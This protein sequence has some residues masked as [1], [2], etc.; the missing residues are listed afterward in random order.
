MP[1]VD[2]AVI[3]DDGDYLK[4]VGDVLVGDPATG[5]AGPAGPASTVPG[6]AGP[7]GAAGATGAAGTPGTPGDWSTAQTVE[8]VA[9]ATYTVVAADA[10]KLKRLAVTATVTLPSAGP[11]AGQRV[12]FACAGVGTFVLGSGATWD[13]APTPSAVA[14]AVGSYVTAVKMGAATWSLT[15][16]LA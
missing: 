11:T 15:G 2:L 1:D 9:G 12:D 10:G 3:L 5:P 13:I 16:D 14:R 4:R 6:P 7:A 8:A